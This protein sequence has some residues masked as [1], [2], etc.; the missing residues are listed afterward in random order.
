MLEN[1][2]IPSNERLS[3]APRHHFLAPVA[4]SPSECPCRAGSALLASELSPVSFSVRRQI[5]TGVIAAVFESVSIQ[6]P[7]TGVVRGICAERRGRHSHSSR[8]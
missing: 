7:V 8:L 6:A 2:T 3:I 4:K 1:R 5:A